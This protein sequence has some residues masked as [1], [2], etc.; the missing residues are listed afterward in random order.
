MAKENFTQCL[1]EK[2]DPDGTKVQ[3]VTFIQ[4][5]HKQRSRVRDEDTNEIWV[6]KEKY[7]TSTMDED[8]VNERSR[9]FKTHRKATDIKRDATR[10][11]IEE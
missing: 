10:R 11:K 5:H 4:A 1:L 3:R 6:V 8:E 7:A 9:D 2:R